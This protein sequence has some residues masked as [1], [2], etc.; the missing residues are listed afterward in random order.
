M[1]PD[2]ALNKHSIESALTAANL[3]A[4]CE[5]SV[6]DSLHST[7]QFL[8][9]HPVE[10]GQAHLCVTENQT[11][12]RGRRGNVWESAPNRNITMSIGWRFT[13]WPTGL[14]GLS[15]AVGMVAAEELNS[16]YGIKVGVKWPNDLL[17]N[18]KKLGGIL[19]ELA[20]QASGSCYVVVGLGLNVEQPDRSKTKPE[21]PA[22]KRDFDW[23]DLSS[24]GLTIDRNKLIGRITAALIEMLGAFQSAG[25]A[26]LK[27][28]WNQ[29]SVYTDQDILVLTGAGQIRGKML[30]VD[31]DGA[32]LMKDDTGEQ[33]RFTDSSVSIRLAGVAD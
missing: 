15:L 1:E 8:L 24:L 17:V 22:T 33:H 2:P 23:Q 10:V 20:G 28:A 14:S 30:G 26:P 9:D 6:F 29:Y 18:G 21:S 16:M 5:V 4:A 32:L 7:N 27:E 31:D 13:E 12:G 19:V 25:F 3:S 11:A